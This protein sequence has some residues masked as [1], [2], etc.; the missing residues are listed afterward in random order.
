MLGVVYVTPGTFL[1]I[2]AAA[3]I[4][5][6]FST[7]VAG[8]GIVVPV[9]VVELLLGVVLGPRVLGLHVNQFTS[10]FSDLGLGLLFFFAGYEI[11]LQR[12]L[13]RPLR[14]ALLGWACSRQAPSVSSGRSCDE[15]GVVER[16]AQQVGEADVGV[17]EGQ[18]PAQRARVGDLEE[19][20]EVAGLCVE[21]RRLGQR[22]AAVR[23]E[24][25]Q[26]VA[27]SARRAGTPEQG[28]VLSKARE[29]LALARHHGYRSE[30][31]IQII[32]R[33]G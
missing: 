28:L 14:L 6:T 23:R 25:G 19:E 8:R 10:F 5:G 20:V 22:E 32:Q 17:F 26:G 29:L 11:D 27:V 24:H 1:A 16:Q 21:D 12:I 2:I 4:A 31:L 33:L 7:L 18:V 15:P 13:G 3:A 9:V 30:E